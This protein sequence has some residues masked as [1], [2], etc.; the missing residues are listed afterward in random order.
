VQ[1]V[2]RASSFRFPRL[3]NRIDIKFRPT[4][5]G[6][7]LQITAP[8]SS[9]ATDKTQI[10]SVPVRLRRCGHEIKM[11]IEGTDP[12]ATAKPDARLIKLLIKACRFNATLVGSDGVP[13]ATLTKREGVSSSYFTRLV[14]LSYLA[15]DI[16]QAMLDGRQ[17]RD[18]TADK[19][20]AHSRLPLT[21]HEQRRVLGFA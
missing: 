12:F 13:F 11:L 6:A 10:L 21:W 17:P 18:L 2:T 1:R 16:T 4:G 20:L 9:N 5:L 19:L 7:L 8:P 15:P 3:A 14:R